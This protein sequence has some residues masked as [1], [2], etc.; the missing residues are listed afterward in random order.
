MEDLVLMSHN[1]GKLRKVLLTHQDNVTAITDNSWWKGMVLLP[2]AN[3]IS[4][5]SCVH[6][7]VCV[8]GGGGGGG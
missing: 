6:V 3:R 7:Y 4:K 8:C 2:W 5:V 1:Q